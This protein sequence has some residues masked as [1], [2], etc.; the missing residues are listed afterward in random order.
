MASAAYEQVLEKARA[1]SPEEQQQLA[2]ELQAEE[3]SLSQPVNGTAPVTN[4]RE[5]E[6][7]W[8][9]DEENRARYGGQWVALDGDQ[10][11]GHS[12]DGRGLYAEAAAKGVALPFVSYVD[13]PDAL[14]FGGW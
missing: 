12:V 8:L 14:P 9:S 6:M 3:Q 4:F 2:R 7:R 5:R 13:P 11:V 1:L 10:L